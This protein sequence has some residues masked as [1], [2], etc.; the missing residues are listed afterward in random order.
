MHERAR[1]NI[2]ILSPGADIGRRRHRHREG[3]T[4][5]T[6]IRSREGRELTDLYRATYLFALALITGGYRDTIL[7]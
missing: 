5:P 4:K 3:C 7:E 2:E 1:A 6:R